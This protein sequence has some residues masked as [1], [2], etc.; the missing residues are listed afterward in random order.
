MLDTSDKLLQVGELAERTGK[1]VRALHLYEEMDLLRPAER[2]K[3]GYRLYGEEAIERV[4]WIGKLQSLGF[5][6]PEIREF[7]KGAENGEHSPGAMMK[8]RSIFAEKLQETRLN[9]QKL[10]ALENELLAS[11]NYLERCGTCRE[12]R[13]P[14]I[15]CEGMVHDL[16]LAPPLVTGLSGALPQAG[17]A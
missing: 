15:E 2:S 11:L 12:Q 9:I 17:K 3:G 4:N 1:T 8:V 6:L 5:S 7:L 14:C 16:N 10:R 13:T